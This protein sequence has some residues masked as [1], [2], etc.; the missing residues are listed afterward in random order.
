[1]TTSAAPKKPAS[2]DWHPADVIAALRKAGWSLQQLAFHHGYTART[3]LANAL[4]RPYPKAEA[5]IA[6][7]LTV[8]PGDIWPSRYEADQV[9][10]NRG[11]PG[12]KPRRPDHVKLVQPTTRGRGRDNQTG[13]RK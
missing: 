3:A 5:I 9:T 11:T 4:H 2:K 7:T 10:P 1:M 12:A 8:K 13:A 6:D